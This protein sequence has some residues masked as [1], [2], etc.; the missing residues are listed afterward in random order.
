MKDMTAT[1]VSD[2][3]NKKKRTIFFELFFLN[4]FTFLLKALTL[5]FQTIPIFKQTTTTTT[6]TS[7]TI[8][9]VSNKQQIKNML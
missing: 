5:I 2:Q 3:I 9:H 1:I 8:K 7:T 4:Y 6:T